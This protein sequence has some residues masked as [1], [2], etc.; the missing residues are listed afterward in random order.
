M[1]DTALDIAHA[2]MIAAGEAD[3]VARLRFLE[4]LCDSELFLLLQ[5]E[6][7]GDDVSP[8]VIEAAG[9]RLVLVFDRETR[10][11]DFA[12]GSAPFAALPGRVL[13]GLLAAENL[14]VAL[15]PEVAPSS[16]LLGAEGVRWL[17]ETLTHG[18][19]EAEADIAEMLPPTGLPDTLLTALDTKLAT[20]IGLAQA[21]YLVG[22][23]NS[24]GAPGHLLGFVGPLPGAED[25]LARAVSE[26][27]TFSGLEAGTLDVAF[28]DAGSAME[29]R[30]S[31]VGLRFD[32]PQPDARVAQAAPGSD[33]DKPPI[34]K[35]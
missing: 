27:L 24:A 11:S 33:P 5:A 2:A 19:Q 14:G 3:D 23:R 28:F 10:L 35:S 13:V 31:R 25:G 12:Q 30:L 22:T 6:A 16:F 8:R 29:A 15:N 26:A 9:E 18:P 21:A 1:T 4:R 7:Q 32:L 17:A 20:A 34:L